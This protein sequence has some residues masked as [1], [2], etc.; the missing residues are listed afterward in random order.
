M[1]T[2][3]PPKL[4]SVV[5]SR[6]SF[7]VDD[8]P[9]QPKAATKRQ[10]ALAKNQIAE[11][12][13]EG[14]EKDDGPLATC[15]NGLTIVVTG[16]FQSITRDQVETFIKEHGGRNT[17]SVSGKTDYLIAGH[18]LED[19]R[20]THTSGKYRAAQKREIPI[21][22]EETFEKFIRERSGISDFCLGSRQ[23]ILNQLG[24]D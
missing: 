21:L 5:K 7:I 23:D 17:G 3:D 8:E 19:G 20:E 13:D 1:N 10:K 24:S 14:E 18:K 22:T 9:S 12:Q 15:L 11:D 2:F 6:K 16:V 4:K